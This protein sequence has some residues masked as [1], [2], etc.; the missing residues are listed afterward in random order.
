MDPAL[1]DSSFLIAL[2]RELAAGQAGPALTWLR[3]QRSLAQRPLLVS[4]ISAAE[5]LEGR[6]DPAEGLAFLAHFVPQNIGFKHAVR[7]AE[8]QRRAGA[9]GR[10]FGENDA[11]Q[12][13]VADRAH[14]TIVGRDRN[15]FSHLGNRYEQFSLR[16]N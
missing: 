8:I 12:M 7:C 4:C 14:A 6:D 11:W 1:L 10:R 9:N 16:E 5:F 15:A 2:E 3:R 13:A